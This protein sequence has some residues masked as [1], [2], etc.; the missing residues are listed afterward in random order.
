MRKLSFDVLGINPEY[1]FVYGNE[2]GRAIFEL[3]VGDSLS[4][5]GKYDEIEFV[6]PDGLHTASPSFVQGFFYGL[7]QY[8]DIRIRENKGVL[9]FTGNLKVTHALYRE[10]EYI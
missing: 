4:A 10:L 3:T 6:F 7:S 1:D 5:D 8:L 9:K 2:P